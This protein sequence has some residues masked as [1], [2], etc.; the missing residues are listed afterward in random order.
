VE[1]CRK[2]SPRLL[3]VCMWVTVCLC[4]LKFVSKLSGTS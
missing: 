4:L 3:L 1:A 2:Q